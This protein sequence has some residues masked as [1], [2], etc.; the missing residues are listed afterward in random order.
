MSVLK[1]SDLNLTLAQRL[2]LLGCIFVVCT[3][4]TSFMASLFASFVAAHFNAG[5]RI[6]AVVQDVMVFI[7]PSLVTAIMVTRRPADLLALTSSPGKNDLLCVLVILI[8]SIPFMESV[9]EWNRNLIFPEWMSGFESKAREMENSSSQPLLRLM[10]DKSVFALILN[11]LIVG[12][13]AGFSEELL[14]RGTFQR[15]LT[16]GGV[17]RHISVWIVA[18]VFSLLHFQ[19]FGFV[20]RLLLGAYFGYL[21]L[22]TGSLWVP[23]TAHILNNTVYVVSS[24]IAVRNGGDMASS[25]VQASWPV[26]LT[27]ASCVATAAA[28]AVIY[29]N[30]RR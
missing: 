13:A 3:V 22:W 10:A 21:L 24:W 14:F 19:L 12:V 17:N 23:M 2:L 20:P 1:K 29:R 16:T 30:H 28:L 15:L 25:S 27:V 8:V 5:F 4:I 26:Y 7:V 11:V 6:V 18:A 9:I